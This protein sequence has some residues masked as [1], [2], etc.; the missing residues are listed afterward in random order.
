[1]PAGPSRRDSDTAMLYLHGGAFVVCGLGTHRSIAARLARA[2]EMPVFS[3]EYRQLP[4]AGVGASVAD[5]VDAYAELIRERH[6]RRVIVAGDSAGGFLAAKV[7]EPPSNGDSRPPPRRSSD[8]R[9][10]STSTW[11]PTR[12][13]PV[14]PT[15]TCRSRRW[16]SWRPSSTAVPCR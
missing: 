14:A 5:A 8:S 12:T 1:M 4:A 16:R 6:Y 15:P 7:I 2:C 10:C 13:G 9:R 3:L 11:A